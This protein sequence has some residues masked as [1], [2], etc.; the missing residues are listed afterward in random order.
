VANARARVSPCA[1]VLSPREAPPVADLRLEHECP[2]AA[3][4]PV[5]RK[6][7]DRSRERPGVEE[8]G[9]VGLDPLGLGL[10]ALDG[11]L[12]V[13]EACPG[14]RLVEGAGRQPGAVLGRWRPVT[15]QIAG[16]GLRD[17]SLHH[18]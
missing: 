2:E 7:P 18:R 11:H 4:P 14:R 8:A 12:A 10:S 15:G 3:Y 16:R 5:G 17:P 6:T 9:E 1:G 13:Q